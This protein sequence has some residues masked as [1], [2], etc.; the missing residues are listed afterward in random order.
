MRKEL[1]FKVGDTIWVESEKHQYA[2]GRV[3]RYKPEEITHITSRS[4]VVN[5]GTWNE[6]KVA[7]K[8]AMNEQEAQQAMWVDKYGYAVQSSA[9]RLRTYEELQQLAKMTGWKEGNRD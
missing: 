5:G 2:P 3:P 9:R 4:Y 8:D 7:F 6:Q 1:R